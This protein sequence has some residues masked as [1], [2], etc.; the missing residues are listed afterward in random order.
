MTFV[1]MPS[2]AKG[3]EQEVSFI[4]NTM[5]KSFFLFV[6]L[7]SIYS[8]RVEENVSSFVE[9][10]LTNKDFKN[11]GKL[12]NEYVIKI[13]NRFHINRFS[14][15]DELKI[16][17]SEIGSKETMGFL[18]NQ[19]QIDDLNSHLSQHYLSKTLSIYNEIYTIIFDGNSN[20]KEKNIKL[21][22][23]IDQ[24]NQALTINDYEFI[25]SCLYVAKS[26]MTLWS[27][28]NIG[29]EGYFDALNLELYGNGKLEQR[30]IAPSCSD[31]VIAGDIAGAAFA[32]LKWGFALAIPGTNAAIAAEIAYETATASATA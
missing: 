19:P 3:K 24:A 4:Y 12:H 21:D 17:T 14:T 28:K 1:D 20:V 10:G 8:C 2:L 23:L 13:M 25:Q 11:I 15:L 18:M 26:S 9:I 30:L 27:A 22:R 6:L 31:D 16:V 32:F 5:K 7:F 29:G